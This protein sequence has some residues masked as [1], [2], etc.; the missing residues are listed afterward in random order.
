MRVCG[1]TWPLVALHSSV[2]RAAPFAFGH[3]AFGSAVL[4]AGCHEHLPAP[5]PTDD[6]GASPPLAPLEAQ[7]PSAVPSGNRVN[8]SSSPVVFDPLRGGVWTANG[9]AG[10]ISYVDV[11]SRRVIE[12]T[13]LGSDIRSIALSPDS[14][15]IAAVDRGAATVTLV[16]ADTRQP[17][18]VLAVG[19]HP[20]SCVWDAADPRWLYV[21]LEDDGAV[22]VVDRTLGKVA[23]TIDVGRLPAGLAVSGRRSELYVAH[24]IDGDITVVDLGGRTVVADVPLADEP[25]SDLTTPNG[26]PLGF[27]SFAL[28]SDGS[29][30]WVPHELLAPTHPFVF[31]ETLFPAISVVDLVARV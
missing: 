28:T 17:R 7:P 24:R 9:D 23:A 18:R 22:A 30:A 15:W 3:L 14:V 6:A 19:T 26:K 21:A 29:H 13:P 8:A 11:E 25:F 16:D 5:I 20:R 2:V 31:N 12:E 10:T 1:S 27:E 4:L